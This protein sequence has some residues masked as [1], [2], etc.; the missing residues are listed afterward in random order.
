MINCD[1]NKLIALVT[2]FR[3]AIEKCDPKSLT[4]EF[5]DFPR[6]SCGDA[7]LLLAK[8]LEQNNCGKFY[9]ILGERSG[10]SHAWLKQRNVIIDITA[11]QFYDNSE[12]VIVTTDHSWHLSFKG[13]AQG[14]ADFEN[15][16]KNTVQKL[17]SAYQ[18]ILDVVK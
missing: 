6:G 2:V 14:I 16:D 13:K 11:D 5:D 1:I 10:K 15:Y 4:V 17:S 7:A 9:Y 18:K 8:Y 3:A 12:A